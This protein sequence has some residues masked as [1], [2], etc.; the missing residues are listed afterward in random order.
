MIAFDLYKTLNRT[1]GKATLHVQ[2]QL[3]KGD[4]AVIYGVSGIGKTTLLRLLAGLTK[5]DEGQ[6]IVD[7]KYWLDSQKNINLPPQQ[8]KV[9]FVFQDYALFPNM[10]IWENLNFAKSDTPLIEELL[11]LTELKQLKN[12]K[13]NKLSGGQQQRVALARAL[14]MQPDILLLDEPLSALDIT[15]RKNMQALILRLH[16]RFQT[17]TLMVSH[18][19]PEIIALANKILVIEYDQSL[20]YDEP[21]AYFQQQKTVQQ[22]RFVGE[23]LAIEGLNLTFRVGET[24][25]VVTLSEMQLKDLKIGDKI[26][27]ETTIIQPTIKKDYQ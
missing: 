19:I 4:L 13:P 15:L 22:L 18:D 25:N 11:E 3:Q 24:I 8:R 12:Q 2:A 27:L 14:V 21:L 20:V 17:T 26:S 5:A 6:I 1:D 10:T 7:E 16:Q 23:V 9:G